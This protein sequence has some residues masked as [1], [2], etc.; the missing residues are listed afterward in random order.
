MKKWHTVLWV[1]FVSLAV[2][3]I[4]FVFFKP[5]GRNE[6]TIA[7]VNG[8]RVYFNDLTKSMADLQD[9]LQALRPY[10]RMYGMSDD[11]FLSSILGDSTPEQIALEGCVR[12]KLMDTVKSQC[13]IRF[14]EEWFKGELVKSLPQLSDE[15]GRIN[16]DAYNQYLKKLEMTSTEYEV[17][18]EEEFKREVVSRFIHNTAYVPRYIAKE[19]IEQEQS[20]KSFKI[21]SIPFSHF[22]AEASKSEPTQ[23]E[24]EEFYIKTKE[25]YRVDE[26]RKAQYWFIEPEEYAKK[27]EIDEQSMRSFYDKNKGTLYRVHPKIKVRHIL[28]KISDK[29]KQAATDVYIRAQQLAKDVKKSPEKFATFAKENSD[30]PDASRGGETDFFGRNTFDHE[31]ERVAF[32]LQKEG[33]VS[34]IVKTKEGYQIVQLVGRQAASEKPFDMVKDDKAETLYKGY[35]CSSSH[36]RCKLTSQLL[37]THNK[38][39]DSWTFLVDTSEDSNAKILFDKTEFTMKISSEN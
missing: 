29:S 35:T 39:N 21:L 19:L 27:I 26:K 14:D 6:V 12:D 38:N 34:D 31:F 10:A 3:G 24:L 22:L 36:T 2:S 7:K 13:N 28:L 15:S 8:E 16:M 20:I 4:S 5:T 33:D 11:A 23:K 1:V 18:R 9:R 32:R 25:A 30:A 17:Q 37:L